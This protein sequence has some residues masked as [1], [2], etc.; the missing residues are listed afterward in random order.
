LDQWRAAL[1]SC[2]DEP[3]EVQ[4][5][6]FARMIWHGWSVLSDPIRLRGPLREEFFR[7]FVALY[8]D[9]W[10][11]GLPRNLVLASGSWSLGRARLLTRQARSRMPLSVVLV[12]DRAR[13]VAVAIREKTRP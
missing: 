6:V 2:A 9:A 12:R 8:R 10:R 11:P 7:R 1:T 4:S 13:T 3:V 5:A